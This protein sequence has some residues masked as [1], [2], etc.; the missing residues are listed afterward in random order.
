MS[1]IHCS[2]TEIDKIN[3]CPHTEPNSMPTDSFQI[4]NIRFLYAIEMLI[5]VR[6]FG[7]YFV[8]TQGPALTRFNRTGYFL[9]QKSQFL[10]GIRMPRIGLVSRHV[11]HDRAQLLST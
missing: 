2:Q 10:N 5:L 1:E 9:V 6:K 11:N 4:K 7:L 3:V 8:Q